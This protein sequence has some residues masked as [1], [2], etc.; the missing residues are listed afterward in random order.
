MAKPQGCVEDDCSNDIFNKLTDLCGLTGVLTV[1][2]T[3]N[4]DCVR[5]S[6]SSN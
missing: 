5:S 4:D 6:G 3:I 2:D 1:T